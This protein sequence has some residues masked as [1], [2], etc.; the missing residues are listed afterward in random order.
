[1][2]SE[3]GEWKGN[4]VLGSE[5]AAPRAQFA[6]GVCVRG[7]HVRAESTCRRDTSGQ[8]FATEPKGSR[9][10]LFL[11][12]FIWEL[13][14]SGVEASS[15]KIESCKLSVCRVVRIFLSHCVYC[16]LVN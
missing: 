2:G 15:V 7:G 1:M 4:D 9:D 12:L 14:V 5:P 8:Q 16:L 11:S 3:R 10:S 13:C 6:V